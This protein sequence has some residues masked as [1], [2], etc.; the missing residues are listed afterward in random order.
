[1]NLSNQRGPMY[2]LYE[3][4]GVLQPA[5]EAYLHGRALTVQDIAALRAYLRQWIHAP[6]WAETPQ[7]VQ[8]RARINTIRGRQDLDKWLSD[9]L[10]E[11][12]DPL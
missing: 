5:V 6:V 4:S 7:L 11:G 10:D 2:W 8:L 1:M 3:T 9:A 12:I